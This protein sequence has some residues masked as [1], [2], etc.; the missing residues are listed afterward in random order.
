MTL[1][2]RQRLSQVEEEIENGTTEISPEISKD[3]HVSETKVNEQSEV[4]EVVKE[5]ENPQVAVNQEDK[6]A[7]KILKAVST[8]PFE[9]FSNQTVTRGGSH[10]EREVIDVILLNNTTILANACG[11]GNIG[12]RIG[13]EIKEDG[14]VTVN[15]PI[16]A[17]NSYKISDSYDPFAN[18]MFDTLDELKRGEHLEVQWGEDSLKD[19]DNRA[20]CFMMSKETYKKLYLQII[21]GLIFVCMDVNIKEEDFE[22]GLVSERIL[23]AVEKVEKGAFGIREVTGVHKQYW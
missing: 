12:Y 14:T 3:T 11:L 1:S 15:T 23:E 20:M 13:I 16:A 22:K 19:L 18:M 8:Y 6:K 21:G 7:E 4:K 9:V 10:G 17:E 2:L 5:S